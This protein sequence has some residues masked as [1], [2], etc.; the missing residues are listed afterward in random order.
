MRHRL[1]SPLLLFL[2]STCFWPT[3][4]MST[5]STTGESTGVTVPATIPAVPPQQPFDPPQI[6]PDLDLNLQ[7]NQTLDSA[8]PLQVYSRRKAPPP[9]SEPVQSSPSEP[10]DVEVIDDFF[11]T[12]E[13][14]PMDIMYYIMN[15]IGV[16]DI[17]YDFEGFFLKI[18]P[19]NAD[20]PS[21]VAFNKM[22]TY[23]R[24][25]TAEIVSVDEGVICIRNIVGRLDDFFDLWNPVTKQNVKIRLPSDVIFGILI[26][27]AFCFNHKNGEFCIILMWGSSG[28][29]DF[30][31]MSTFKSFSRTWTDFSMPVYELGLLFDNS[32]NINGCSYW[33]SSRKDPRYDNSQIVVGYDISTS[34]SKIFKLPFVEH[35]E[36]WNFTNVHGKLGIVKWWCSSGIHNT[37]DI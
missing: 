21:P 23:F 6:S 10:Q 19:L 27:S 29:N 35:S 25:H 24:S 22:P 37:Y 16:E 14:L 28:V 36:K 1:P 20:E 7:T 18:H 5:S 31:A 12:G 17:N 13:K 26:R 8:R 32:I 2:L 34:N 9:T 15:F 3:P 11:A 30:S 33:L 4:A